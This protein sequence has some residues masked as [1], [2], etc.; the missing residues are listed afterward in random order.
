MTA[1]E[2]AAI[3]AMA[4]PGEPLGRRAR[5]GG[6]DALHRERPGGGQAQRLPA[7]LV[8]S[9]RDQ[10]L[11]QEQA[12]A[13]A[14]GGDD[15]GC[16]RDGKPGTRGEDQVRRGQDYAQGRAKP[17]PQWYGMNR[18]ASVSPASMPAAAE[19]NSSPP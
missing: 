8:G 15:N 4:A 7:Q 2:A 6:T 1:S 9:Q 14:D 18:P 3:A 13:V 10:A 19:A 5:N 16:Y 12:G 11:L 17:L